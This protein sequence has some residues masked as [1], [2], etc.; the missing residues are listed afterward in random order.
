MGHAIY[1]KNDPRARI[2][3]GFVKPLAIEKVMKKNMNYIN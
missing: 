3:K 1:S 2:L